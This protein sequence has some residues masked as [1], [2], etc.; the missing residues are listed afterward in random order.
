MQDKNHID[1]ILAD[2]KAGKIYVLRIFKKSMP[3]R[4]QSNPTNG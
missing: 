1:I 2:R 3:Q 4:H